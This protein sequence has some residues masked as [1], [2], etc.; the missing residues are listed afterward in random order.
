MKTPS[1]STVKDVS[2]MT[3]FNE[4]SQMNLAA[5]NIDMNQINNALTIEYN[6]VS[7]AV[8]HDLY[9]KD[10]QKEMKKIMSKKE[11]ERR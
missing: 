8:T 1:A 11:L 10:E 5:A 6:K 9:L 7:N 3:A 4:A 2:G